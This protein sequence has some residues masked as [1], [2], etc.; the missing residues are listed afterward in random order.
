MS[1]L[2]IRPNVGVSMEDRISV[3]VVKLKYSPI[4]SPY[5]VNILLFILL[6]FEFILFL[7][8]FLI[9]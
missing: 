3:N 9:L 4:S 5:K 8:S 2:S 1:T 6:L 7:K